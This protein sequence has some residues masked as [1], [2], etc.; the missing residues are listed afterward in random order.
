M[1]HRIALLICYAWRDILLW[2]R[3][4]EWNTWP[5]VLLIG[6]SSNR[7]WYIHAW[8]WCD[9]KETIKC[10][11]RCTFQYTHRCFN[12]KPEHFRRCHHLLF[13]ENLNSLCDVMW[14]DKMWA[15]HSSSQD[16]H[17][18]CPRWCSCMCSAC[19]LSQSWCGISWPWHSWGRG[20]GDATSRKCWN[21]L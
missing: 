21:S 12:S 17:S 4:T 11:T 16:G 1:S 8:S 3:R 14:C 2:L 19:P 6:W 20:Q 9:I 5:V 10:I 7:G 13:Q 18:L 15:W